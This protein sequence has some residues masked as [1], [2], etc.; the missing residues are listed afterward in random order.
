VANPFHPAPGALPARIVG[1]DAELAAM[2]EAV[3][4]AGLGQ[5]P[6]PTVIIGQRG[7]GKTVLLRHLRE[8][9]GDATLALQLETLPGRTLGSRVREKIDGLLTSVEPLPARAGAVLKRAVKALPK[10][11]YELPHQAGAVAFEAGAD[12]AARS[13]VDYESL[14]SMLTALQEAA[15][16]ARRYVTITIDE[17]QDADLASVEAVTTF[18]HESAQGP[19]PILLALAGLSETRDLMDKLR[20]YVH[21]WDTFEL[22]LLTLSE[23]IE[24]IRE[25]IV[26]QGHVIDEDALYLLATESGGY[27]YFIQAYA[28]AAWEAHRGKTIALG[29]VESSLP[30]VRQRNEMSFYLRPLSKLT[31][32]ETLVALTLACLG[33]GTHSVGEVARELGVKAPDISSIRGALVKKHLISSPIPG[34]IEFRIPFTDRFL[35]EHFA[36]YDTPE[37]REARAELAASASKSKA[38]KGRSRRG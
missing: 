3:R 28:S 16:V 15:R 17:A 6:T 35:R 36:D 5:A 22:R 30:A 8:L 1:R 21:R 32:R 4:R 7:M 31:P 19:R 11:S 9:A 13:E 23:S 18:V 20:T 34:K 37:V 38:A 2:R 27:P 12:S 33:P 29:D 26:A 24:A 10:I 25:P 14:V